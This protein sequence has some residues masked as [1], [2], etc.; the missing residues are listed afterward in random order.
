MSKTSNMIFK[1]YGRSYHLKIETAEDLEHVVKLNEAH[2]VATGVP[3]AMIS[4]D[5]VFL[6]LLDSGN[7]GRIMCREVKDAIHWLLSA[8]CDR[9]GDNHAQ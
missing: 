4:C 9:T 7:N 1:R 3:T 6:Q 8:L 2:W 5:R